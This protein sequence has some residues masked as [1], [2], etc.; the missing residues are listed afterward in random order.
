MTLLIRAKNHDRLRLPVIVFLSCF[1]I[2]YFP[3]GS[4]TTFRRSGCS[5]LLLR[6]SII[7]P[8]FPSIYSLVI[9]TRPMLS[10]LGTSYMMSSI[11]SSMMARSAL[12][13]VSFSIALSAIASSALR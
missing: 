6:M 11:N 10:S 13:P 1:S 7:G 5:A 2:F 12:A 8:P 3:V 9:V 4:C